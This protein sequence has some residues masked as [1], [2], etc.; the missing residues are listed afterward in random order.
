DVG[1]G[2]VGGSK[3][4]ILGFF[5]ARGWTAMPEVIRLAAEGRIDL[6]KLI[7]QRFTFDQT[8]EAY[9]LLNERKILGRG[10]IETNPALA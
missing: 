4:L 7:T 5:G 9:E 2:K 1:I 8:A 3:L 6:K 10:L